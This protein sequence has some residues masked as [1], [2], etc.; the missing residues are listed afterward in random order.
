[1]ELKKVN[2]FA[3]K[4]GYDHAKF[5]CTWR[6]FRCYEP[7]MGS[8]GTNHLGLPLLILVD[9]AGKIRMS[10]PEEAME[11]LNDD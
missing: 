6:G 3:E 10:T 7:M 4:Q 9:Q 11:Q 8:E 1:M 5:L 2:A